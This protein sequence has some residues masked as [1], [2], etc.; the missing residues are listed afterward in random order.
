MFLRCK[1]F[2][3][4]KNV[5]VFW[6]SKHWGAANFWVKIV[7]EGHLDSIG[8]VNKNEV[9]NWNIESCDTKQSPYLKTYKHE[10]S[11]FPKQWS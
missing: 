1:C 3:A 8:N 2:Y 5:Y 6:S 11:K 4:S 7:D 10:I 9:G